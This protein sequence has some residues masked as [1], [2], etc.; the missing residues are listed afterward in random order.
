MITHTSA[1]IIRAVSCSTSSN[2][3]YLHCLILRLRQTTQLRDLII[4]DIMRKAN[5]IIALLYIFNNNVQ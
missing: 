3:R 1:L 4:F 2:N 5:L